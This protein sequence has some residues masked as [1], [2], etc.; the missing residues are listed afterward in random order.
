MA[1]TDSNSRILPQQKVQWFSLKAVVGRK[2]SHHRKN[3]G[4][5]YST[6]QFY[7]K[8]IF[9]SLFKLFLAPLNFFFVFFE[10]YKSLL[11]IFR[12]ENF[13]AFLF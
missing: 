4:A 8:S 5:P 3:G 6:T 2:N 1:E 13:Q 7:D 10:N 9:R 11:A 12:V